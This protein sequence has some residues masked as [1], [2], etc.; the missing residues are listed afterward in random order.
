RALQ[1]IEHRNRIGPIAFTGLARRRQVLATFLGVPGQVFLA[2]SLHEGK[3][4]CPPTKADNRYPDQFLFEKKL[5]NRHPSTELVLQ[6]QNI[7]P[8]LMVA[9][10]Q[11]RVAHI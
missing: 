5:E 4:Q 1:K 2:E 7:R 9:D 6:Y 8:A 11:V 10:D 3:L